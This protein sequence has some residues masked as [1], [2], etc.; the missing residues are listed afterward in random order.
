LPF[1]FNNI[2]FSFRHCLFHLCNNGDST[3]K[4]DNETDSLT[5][6][7]KHLPENA[8][9]GLTTYNGL[10]IKSM[11]TEP[12]LRNPTNIDVDDRGRVWVTEAYNY[13]PAIN[14]N[15]TDSTGDRIMIL[16]DKDGDGVTET[17]KVFYQGPELNAPLG[18]CVLGNRVLVSQSPYVWAFY[19]DNGDDKADRKEIM[20]QGLSGEQHDHGAHTFTF[21][22]DGKL[23]F[24]LGNEGKTLKDKNGKTVRDL[25]GNE[26]VPERYRQGITLRCD[27]DGSNVEVLGQNFRNPYEVAVDS[28]GT[29]WQSDNDDD[30][31]RGTRINYVMDYGNYGYKDELTNASWQENRTNVEDSTPLKHWHLNDPGVVPNLLQTFAGSPTGMVIYEGTLLPQQFQN[32]MIHCDPG[33]NVVRSY[34]VKK[35]GA[36]YSAEIVNMVK[37]EKDK[38]FRPA[39]IC[40]A[41]DGSLIIAD[42]YDVGVGGHQAGDQTRGRIYRLAPPDTKYKIPA[43]NYTTPEGAVTALQNPNLAVRYKAW[44]ALQSM[45]QAAV[46]VLENLWNT[47]ANPKM[48]ARAFWALIKMPGA[49]AQ[50]YISQAMQQNNPDFRIMAIRAAREMK[51]DVIGVVRRLVNDPD[52]QVRR[53]CALA[54]HH[55]KAP[56]A[57]ELWSTLATRH[58]GK[59]RWYLEA[60]GVGADEQWN[61]FFPAYLSKVK[62]PLQNEASRD[63]VWRSRTNAATPFIAQLAADNQV[64]LNNRLRYFRAFDYNEGPASS[65]LLLKMIAGEGPKDTALSRLVLHHLDVGTVK[66]SMVAQAALK[67]L[68]KTTA[69]TLEYLDLVRRYELKSENRNLLELAIANRDKPIGRNAAGL[70]LKFGGAPLVVNAINTKDS[71]RSNA[72]ITSLGRAGS[73]ESVDILQNITLSKKYPLELRR[74]AASKIGKS[75]DGEKRVLELLKNKKVPEQLI[76]DVVASV[77]QAW[78]KS[79]RNEA[80]S[81][82]PN[83]TKSV[84]KKIPTMPELLAL[85]ANAANGKAMFMNNCAVCHQVNKEGFD[86][87]PN[88][89]EIGSKYPKEGL[90]KS[91]VYPSEGISFNSEGWELKLK[92]GSTLTGIIASKTETDI[93]LKLPG[94]AKQPIKTSDVKSMKQLKVSMM[95]EGLHENMSTQ[96]LANLLEYL[97]GLKKKQ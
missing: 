33:P 7:Q 68:L 90:L 76:P 22:P 10:E 59:D 40:V 31:N 95:P 3:S 54:L 83:A 97:Q 16:E 74:M 61:T 93:A 77:Q 80:L 94:G 4:A 56:E 63:I 47:S 71:A 49:N 9:K 15:P 53:E 21:G 11:A 30:G 14:G 29:M 79:V 23:Y 42:W 6:E 38:W 2:S 72:L 52:A 13:R 60:L 8:L 36:G 96:D 85:K 58:D 66:G 25:E 62:D 84:A 35:N 24:N 28:Y 17:A 18:I 45:G 50:Q 20:F 87:G 89:S 88:L 86:F 37:G 5:E 48:R 34:P 12:M 41:P 55:N 51:A 57:A 26:I 44:T 82:L 81:Y 19:D 70:L 73:K 65:R 75:G 64:A 91:I 27:P 1:P 67:D 32:Q 46:P 92:D 69:G 39:D 43:Q 78:Q